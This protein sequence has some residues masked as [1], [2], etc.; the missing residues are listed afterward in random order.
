MYILLKIMSTVLMCLKD[1][2]DEMEKVIWYA[3]LYHCPEKRDKD[4]KKKR[5]FLWLKDFK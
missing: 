4:H 5:K 3:F 2:P 1:M